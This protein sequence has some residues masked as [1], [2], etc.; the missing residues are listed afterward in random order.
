MP[1]HRHLDHRRRGLRAATTTAKGREAAAPEPRHRHA[2]PTGWWW[3]TASQELPDDRLAARLDGCAPAALIEAMGKLIE[4]NT[5]RAGVR[6]A[7]GWRRWRPTSRA[8]PVARMKACRDTRCRRTGALPGVSVAAC[9]TAACT[10]SSAS[11]A[12]R[13]AWPSLRPGGRGRPGVWRRARPS[14]RGGRGLAALVFRLAG[15]GAADGRGGAAGARAAA[16]IRRFC[17]QL[18]AQTGAAPVGFTG[19]RK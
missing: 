10:P 3:S 7:P 12:R 2:R 18:G 9:R 14:A 8:R 15:P 6:A 19:V 13:L 16:I 11:R 5:L 4:F 17:A 1:P